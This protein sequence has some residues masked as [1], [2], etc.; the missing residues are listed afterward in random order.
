MNRHQHHSNNDVL[1]APAGVDID[2][3]ERRLA[4]LH[5][6]ED[7]LPSVGRPGARRGDEPEAGEVRVEGAVDDLADHFTRFHIR[8]EQSD[9][10][11]VPL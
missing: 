7:E 2:Q 5:G 1:G 8:E 10:H 11:D 9:R 3:H 4:S 6:G